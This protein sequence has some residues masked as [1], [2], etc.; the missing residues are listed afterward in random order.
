MKQRCPNSQPLFTATLPNYKLVFTER[1][2]TK[3]D[4]T[5]TIQFEKNNKVLGAIY[6]VPDNDLKNLDKYEGFPYVYDKITVDVVL[7]KGEVVRAITYVK[8]REM[9]V[10]QPSEEYGARIQEGYQNWGIMTIEEYK[11]QLHELRNLI[12]DG[13]AYFAAWCEIENLDEDSVH[14][15]NRYRDFFV[16]VQLSLKHMA[17]LQFAKV[18]DRNPRAVS[19]TNLLNTAKANPGVFAPHA[20]INDLQKVEDMINNNEKLRNNLKSFRDQRLAH[21][22]KVLSRNQ[23]LLL[24]QMK[25]L[26]DETKEMYNILS[27]GHERSSAAFDSLYNEVKHSTSSVKQIMLEKLNSDRENAKF[28]KFH[29]K[30]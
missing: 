9:K 14:A 2:D 20:E 1:S 21:H 3:K 22:D 30:L 29:S 13:V 19:I 18:F 27:L 28:A 7:Y 25:K 15:L 5:A 16:P 17:I 8:V 24:G 6:E 23:P 10:A 11:N 12:S 26:I 4:G